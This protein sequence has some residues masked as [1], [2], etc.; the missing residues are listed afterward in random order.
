ML[1]GLAILDSWSAPLPI[2]LELILND[3][4]QVTDPYARYVA[5]VQS[6]GTGKS[7]VHDEICE[8]HPLYSHQFLKKIEQ[9][10]Y[11]SL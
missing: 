10:A 9:D 8:T 2:C 1:P 6:S 11:F 7:R 5:H 4:M 3:Y